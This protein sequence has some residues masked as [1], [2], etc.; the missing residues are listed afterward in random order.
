M[1]QL[2]QNSDQI[3]N[4][5]CVIDI[6]TT[7][8]D[9]RTDAII[10]VAAIKF[11]LEGISETYQS[12]VNPGRQIPPFISDLT[13]I[14]DK[15]VLLAPEFNIII[16][17]LKEFIGDSI[18]IGHNVGFDVGFLREFGFSFE[19]ILFDTLDLSYV[20]HP[21]QLDY[22]LT[23]L[24]LFLELDISNSHRAMADCENTMNLFIN[25]LASIKNLKLQT[26][27]QINNMAAKGSW[28]SHPLLQAL[29]S[30][31]LLS[32][33]SNENPPYPEADLPVGSQTELQVKG[34]K[35]SDDLQEVFSDHGALAYSLSAFE[36]RQEQ[37]DM[38]VMVKETIEN[39]S[40]SVIEAGTGVGKSMAYLIPAI[41][42]AK[43]NDKRV[44]ISTNTINLQDQLMEEDLPMAAYVVKA[45]YTSDTD[46]NEIRYSVLKGRRNYLCL[47]N[48][49]NF[50]SREQ[51]DKTETILISKI[52]V[53]LD[54]T[55][56]G[57]Q[58]E[59]NLS[60]TQHRFLWSRLNAEGAFMC[61]GYNGKCFLKQAREE[62][63]TSDLVIVNHSL[64]MADLKSGRSLLPE[65]GALVIDEAHHLEDQATQ[66]FGFQVSHGLAG[67]T[68]SS[69]RGRD[70]IFSNINA[71][72]T[73]LKMNAEDVR[74]LSNSSESVALSLKKI[75]DSFN[76]LF[77]SATEIMKQSTSHKSSFSPSDKYR[78]KIGEEPP[79]WED[80]CS[81]GRDIEE[82][83]SAI[84]KEFVAANRI[85]EKYENHRSVV[86]ILGD[87]QNTQNS[88]TEVNNF[89]Q[90]FLFERTENYVYWI[91]H[92]HN[93]DYSTLSGAPIEV[94]DQLRDQLFDQKFSVVIT[95][96]TL[97]TDGSFQ[98]INQRLGINPENQLLL[99]SPFPYEDL[100]TVV[101]PTDIP[102]PR[103]PYYEE[104]VAKNIYQAA[105]AAG[106]R[107]IALFTSYS[108]LKSVF[109]LLKEEYSGEHL[110]ILAQGIS[111]TPRQL[112]ERMKKHP[113][114]VLLGTSSFW[115]GIDLRGDALQIL[116]ITRLP[117]DVPSDPIY[118]ARAEKYS[119]PF[120]EY[121]LPSAIIR[122]RQGFGRLV[123]SK[124][125]RGA[126]FILDSR[127]INSRYGHRFI[128]ALPKMEIQRPKSEEV[129]GIVSNW[130]GI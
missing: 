103:E 38:A 50:A 65:F 10:E 89:I 110:D 63:N 6:E 41:Q 29:L 111:G 51:L 82:H 115:E 25:L 112:I 98:H 2:T 99:G 122:F 97:S 90:H 3:K 104:M 45:A 75:Q 66:A 106:G 54:T 70:S 64:L 8:L 26:F 92:D 96:A 48:F 44:V 39:N 108:S 88:V 124:K 129:E 73:P 67:E 11:D 27:V 81:L 94:G 30:E 18:L 100:A 130:L 24:S 76:I 13:G 43:D 78:I 46:D 40:T 113:E 120:M 85:L 74:R 15:D 77:S 16:P 62:A 69:L 22:S 72:F 83:V 47:K 53:W 127:V 19:G 123:R 21:T 84:S 52:L 101:M 5:Y 95:S 117:F 58:A 1:T 31:R 114:T 121:A 9:N 119:N 4:N 20:I 68:L 35:F 80:L 59:L 61:G 60:R 57:D 37:L 126:V 28:E 116:V 42:Y 32:E 36:E 93:P 33:K 87:I 125:D 107:T 55:L 17:E 34:Q 109:Q 12:F 56:T 102:D 71:L 23:G 118:A 105:M 79:L 86:E 128:K 91:S 14:F 7:G 49:R